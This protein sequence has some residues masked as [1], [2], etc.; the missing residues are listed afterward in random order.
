MTNVW[1]LDD[2]PFE[3]LSR[4]LGPT[5]VATLP[6]HA[7]FVAEATASDARA[8]AAI[9]K[10]E[11]VRRTAVLQ[12]NP[13]IVDEFR[14]LVG[15][16]AGDMLYKH[17]RQPVDVT[18]NLAENQSI[19]W[20]S[21]DRKD[22]TF[23]LVERRG[24]VDAMSELGCGRVAHAFDLWLWLYGQNYISEYQFAELCRQTK[25]ADQG[26]PDVPLRCKAETN[27]LK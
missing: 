23:V 2:G 26:L 19:A 25:G 13:R 8:G 14:I 3:W 17:L 10:P 24:C 11:A 27:L 9:N 5:G 6:R 16:P 18:K 20:A 22:A 1:I 4:V 12:L 21:T 15:S 7:L